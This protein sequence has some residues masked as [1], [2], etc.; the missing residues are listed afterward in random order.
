MLSGGQ[1]SA[2]C[3]AWAASKYDELHFVTFHYGQR[4]K[5]EIDAAFEIS[6]LFMRSGN[7]HDLIEVD[8]LANCETC[9]LTNKDVDVNEVS[10]ESG[11]PKSFLPGRNLV[12]LTSAASIALSRGIS[13]VVTGVCQ[14]DF[15]GYPDC[16]RTTIDALASAI[17]SGNKGLKA[18][19]EFEIKTPLMYISKA[20]TVKLARDLDKGWEALALSWT[21]YEGGERPCGQCPA[22]E[23]RAKGFTEAGESDPALRD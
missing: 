17:R 9:G 10:E 4:H 23:L 22:C 1:D 3:A 21:C 16:R 5:R 19:E 12:F 13:H 7:R 15:S 20:E 2:T 6:K 14:T 18:A 11:L 8:A